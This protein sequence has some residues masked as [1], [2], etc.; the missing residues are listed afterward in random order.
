M[1]KLISKEGRKVIPYLFPGI[2]FSIVLIAYP[3]AYICIMAFCNNNL[4]KS[5]FVGFMNFSRLFINPQFKN[6]IINTCKLVP[7]VVIISFLL[8]LLLAVLIARPH[9][10]LKGLWRSVIFIAW[11][12]PG[13]VKATAWKWIFE[14]EN[15]ILNHILISAHII[16][17]PVPWLSNPSIALWSIIL[18]EIW[19]FTPFVMVMLNASLLQIPADIYE[20]ADIEGANWFV[21]LTRITMPM[22]SDISFVCILILFAWALNEFIY[23]WTMTSGGQ[24]T[25]TLSILIYNLFKVMNINAASASALMQLCLMLIPAALYIRVV[26]GDKNA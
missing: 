26:K 8:G 25:T 24:N 12:V 4:R 18:V 16:E 9:T 19:A 21:K 22:I 5:R 15:G 20:S 7:M 3:L 11:I 17:Y 10:K 13:I 6:A 23:I 2:L 14:T 1:N